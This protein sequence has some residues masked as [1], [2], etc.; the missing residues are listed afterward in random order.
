MSAYNV[1]T[2][3]SDDAANNSTHPHNE[4]DCYRVDIP[5]LR[6][7]HHAEIALV[8]FTYTHS[9]HNVHDVNRRFFVKVSLPKPL[10]PDYEML[11][12]G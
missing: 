3:T 4:P 2:I 7:P 6:W 5:T 1:V 8:K 12:N 9:F 11:M 10:W